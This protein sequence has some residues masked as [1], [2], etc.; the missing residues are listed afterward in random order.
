M[1]G[2]KDISVP[3]AGHYRAV[4]TV[5]N[6]PPFPAQ[7]KSKGFGRQDEHQLLSEP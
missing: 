6:I 7:S 5:E 4:R 1:V 3:S 2:I